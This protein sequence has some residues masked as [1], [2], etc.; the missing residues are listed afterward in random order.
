MKSNLMNYGR[1]AEA[2]ASANAAQGWTPLPP[3]SIL[4]VEDETSIRRLLVSLLSSEGYRIESVADGTLALRILE[5]DPDIDLVLTDLAMPGIPGTVVADYLSRTRPEVKVV[6][7]SGNPQAH[8][9]SLLRLLERR[10][11][12]FLPKPFTPMQV[13]QMV[14]RLLER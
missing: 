14:K 2:R 5:D 12:D 6:C 1:E 13:L 8:E 11:V 9:K 4:I 7:M 10:L 3:K